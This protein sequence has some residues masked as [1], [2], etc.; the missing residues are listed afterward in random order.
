MRSPVFKGGEIFSGTNHA[1][2][3]AGLAAVTAPN[4]ERDPIVFNGVV[5]DGNGNLSENTVGV[6]P[7][8]FYSAIT[9]RSGNL[10]INEA[11]VYDATNVRL[12]NVNLTYTF[13]K[14]WLDKVPFQGLSVGISANNVWMISSNLDGVDPEAVNATNSNATGFEN[15]APPTT[16]T[17]FL[18]ISAKF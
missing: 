3:A 6:A 8:I 12:R 7:E 17:V 2:Q 1:L 15:L 14:A 10:G 16:R 13:S 9:S 11:F 18:N 4:G 5:D